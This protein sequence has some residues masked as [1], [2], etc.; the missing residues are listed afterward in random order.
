ML[1]TNSQTRK[2]G[3][4]LAFL[5]LLLSL[6]APLVLGAAI[7]GSKVEYLDYDTS[8]TLLTL[9]WAPKLATISL[10]FALIALLVSLFMAPKR[11]GPFALAAVIISGSV[12]GGFYVYERKLKSAPPIYD[13]ATDWQRPLTFSEKLIKDRGPDAHPVEDNPRVAKG[14]SFEWDLKPVA[15]V[16]AATCSGAQ[17]V[18][19]AN[20]TADKVAA[21]LMHEGYMI[22]GRS[23][24]RIEAVYRDP[25]Y[26]F[27]SDIVVR[28]DPD[29]TDVRSVSRHELSDLGRNCTRVMRVVEILKAM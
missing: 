2:R 9:N 29:K 3:L 18:R 16:N 10:V 13:V 14:S 27:K 7:F 20:I 21:S 4:S 24:W 17:P 28:I 23:P 11:T 22:F 19:N 25:I 12:L 6:S 5:A 1:E 26:G 8:F 15:D